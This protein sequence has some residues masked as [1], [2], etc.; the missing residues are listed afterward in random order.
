MPRRSG[1][2]IRVVLA[3]LSARAQAAEPAHRVVTC[4][5]QIVPGE[6]VLQVAVP[7]G[8]LVKELKVQRGST[9]T[10]GT[11]LAV[12]RDND[13]ARAD[14]AR[15][16]R[17]VE[18]AKAKLTQVKAGQRREVIAAQE[19]LVRARRAE[20]EFMAGRDKRY[21]Q[22][23]Q[24]EVVSSD[25]YE[26]LNQQLATAEA[27]L[28]REESLL[29]SYRQGRKEDVDVAER[30]LAVALADRDRAEASVEMQVVR[31]PMSGEVVAVHTYSGERAGADGLL[32]LADTAHMML[33]AE[34]YETDIARV[35]LDDAAEAKSMADPQVIRGKVVEIEHQVAA[36]KI[37]P[38]DSVSYT[39]RRVVVVRIRPDNPAAI[40][41]LLNAQVTVKISG[42]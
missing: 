33:L 11:V 29:E 16:E 30:E 15:A 3:L 9:V 38:V 35:R 10:K 34:V 39:D 13:V 41:R 17:N 24:G 2:L 26:E 7:D 19:N 4:L 28:S 5:G 27:Q 32:D 14:L 31:A 25:Q 22:M 37:L 36:G 6:R 21:K 23:Y 40:A 1:V 42:R 18:L 20:A 12:L 8:A